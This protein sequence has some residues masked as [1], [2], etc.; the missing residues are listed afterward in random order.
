MLRGELTEGDTAPV[1]FRN[2]RDGDG[3]D[4]PTNMVAAVQFS[5]KHQSGGA[6]PVNLAACTVTSTGS[7]PLVCEW[8]PGA[9]DLDTA[10]TYD[11][12]LVITYTSG[13]IK[14]F[15][16]VAGGFVIVVRAKTV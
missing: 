6:I 5:L 7:S 14:R 12:E 2:F 10:G 4:I 9:A 16:S 13:R 15:P 11:A 3:A 8:R 1:V